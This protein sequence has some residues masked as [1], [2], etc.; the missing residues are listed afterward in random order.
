MKPVHSL[1]PS[2]GATMLAL[3]AATSPAWGADRGK[4]IFLKKGCGE[5]HTIEGPEVRLPVTE[6]HKLKGPTL[7]Y[8][9]SKFQPGYLGRWLVKPQAFRG[10][11]WGTM[12][13]GRTPHPAL[14]PAEA[15]E[16]ARFLEGLKDPELREGVVPGWG[17]K[18]PRQVLRRARI[19]FQ[20]E[21]PCYACHMVHIRKTVYRQAVE[22]GGFTGPHLI[23]AGLRLR[24]DFIV[25]LL[26]SPD[27]YAP[28]GRM[29]RYGDKAFT[30][31]SEQDLIT[32]A[33]YIATLK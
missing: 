18:L 25:A 7:W 28:N 14:P 21:Q 24:P 16:V 3:L 31:L 4:D 10:V 20:K 30:P 12:E 15:G 9:G 22:V 32:L 1:F 5:C 2:I 6:R 11:K 29:P 23:D 19:L 13:K 8:A 27:R 33:A 26:K 17:D